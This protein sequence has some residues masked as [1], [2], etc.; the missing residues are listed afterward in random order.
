MTDSLFPIETVPSLIDHTLLKPDATEGDVRRLC[1]EAAHFGFAA[2]CVNPYWVPLAADRLGGTQVRVCTV[3]GF[4]L[5]A[6]RTATKMAEARE[7]LANRAT[8]L[9]MVINVGALRSGHYAAVSE[10]IRALA[11]LAHDGGAI[12][13]VILE[14]CLLTREEKIAAA[15]AAVEAR[16]DFV[17]TS[18]GF[19]TGGA[20]V[21]DVRLL[22]ETVGKELG[23][24]A[25][26]GVR[27]WAAL[28]EMVRAGAT[29]IGTSSG[30]SIL[31]EMEASQSKQP[32]N[33]IN[34]D[35]NGDASENTY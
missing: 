11:A 28:Q 17:K 27:T 1:E 16:A 26:G 21:D 18:T 7:A 31:R 24:K 14:T 13:K 20:T 35:K 15:K 8:E 3:I 4:P 32:S 22:R 25:S 34:N 9:D 6:N 33:N 30:V 29:R 10:E 5:G 19:S 2:V 12:L 23:V